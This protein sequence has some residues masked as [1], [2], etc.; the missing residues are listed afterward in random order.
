MPGAGAKGAG[1]V[2]SGVDE[3]WFEPNVRSPTIRLPAFAG[4]S[5][6]VIGAALAL[7]VGLFASGYASAQPLSPNADPRP[8]GP[9]PPNI[10]LAPLK[11]PADPATAMAAARVGEL[12]AIPPGTVLIRGL[13][14][15]G[16]TL[17]AADVAR[18]PH[19]QVSVSH[20]AMT[21]VY[22]GP[23]VSDLLHDVGAPLGVRLHGQGVNDVL[24]VT[25]KDRYRAVFSL[26]EVDPS[27]HKGARLI[28]ADQADGKPLDARD[29]PFRLVVDGDLKPARSVF[30][31]V[32]IE[33]KHLP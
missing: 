25:G 6:R 32:A 4:M 13:S 30:G 7:G 31:V 1:A 3:G 9:L 15:P 5:G 22:S 33:L 29:G 14:G 18:L 16:E 28:L 26:A 21:M 11:P 20:G 24:F 27:F 23:V 2:R 19:E 17:T 12:P 8:P 10:G